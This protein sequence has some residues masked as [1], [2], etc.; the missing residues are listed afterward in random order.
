MKILKPILKLFRDSANPPNDN[1]LLP[2]LETVTSYS[3][4][5]GTRFGSGPPIF[6]QAIGAKL[7]AETVTDLGSGPYINPQHLVH[8]GGPRSPYLKTGEVLAF[9]L[10]IEF[11]GGE[12]NFQK[13][14]SY[15]V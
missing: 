14:Y 9:N 5:I 1:L 8:V 2:V 7:F 4:L 12:S 10:I 6:V 15:D 3:P 11:L 13:P